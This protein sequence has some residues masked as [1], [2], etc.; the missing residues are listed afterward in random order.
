MIDA[1]DKH[2]SDPSV[3][4]VSGHGLEGWTQVTVVLWIRFFCKENVHLLLP[5]CRHAQNIHLDPPLMWEGAYFVNGCWLFF[6]M[7]RVDIGIICTNGYWR[8][9][10]ALDLR[11]CIPK[12]LVCHKCLL[13]LNLINN[14][15]LLWQFPTKNNV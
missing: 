7:K 15:S 3:W 6:N 9:L 10:T 2:Q 1:N 11:F 13:R 12:G 8:C 5:I 14:Y 4:R